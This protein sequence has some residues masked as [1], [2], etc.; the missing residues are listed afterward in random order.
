MTT[1]GLT[2]PTGGDAYRHPGWADFTGAFAIGTSVSSATR[3]S[4]YG[5]PS[6]LHPEVL[7]G[8]WVALVALVALCFV[9][10]LVRL[11]RPPRIGR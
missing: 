5:S 6:A 11:R 9:P 10:V 3:T 8:W 4:L 7:F 2:A 1:A